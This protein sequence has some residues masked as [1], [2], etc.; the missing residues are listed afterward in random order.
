M[1]EDW[2]FVV[3][4]N[5]TGVLNCMRAQIPHLIRP[6][7]SI[8]NVSSTCGIRGMARTAPYTASKFGVLGLTK[9]A[10]AEYGPEGIR[11][12]AILPYY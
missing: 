8:V 12:N 4:V 1:Q 3:G 2:D 5:L 11:V 7:G 10:A 9:T 6:G